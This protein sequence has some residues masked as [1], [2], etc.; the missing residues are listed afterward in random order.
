V[1]QLGVWLLLAAVSVVRAVAGDQAP[2]T[3]ATTSAGNLAVA[4]PAD[5]FNMSFTGPT[6]IADNAWIR[7]TVRAALFNVIGG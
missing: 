5:T 1:K 3:L 2:R 7:D 4:R 6:Y